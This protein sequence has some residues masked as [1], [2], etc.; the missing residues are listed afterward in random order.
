MHS[1]SVVVASRNST[2]KESSP[3]KPQAKSNRAGTRAHTVYHALKEDICTGV[4]VPNTQLSEARIAVQYGTSRTPVREALAALE[5]EG[6]VE[7]KRG[8]GA[9]VTPVTFTDLLHI[10]ELR[11]VLEP[12]AARTAYLH[13]TPDEL[14]QW[15]RQFQQLLKN[16]SE[17]QAAII[18]RINADCDFHM[19]V[20]HKSE[21]PFIADM[22]ELILPTIRR[23]QVIS[24]QPETYCLEDAVDQHMQLLNAL[25]LHDINLFCTMLEKHLDWSLANYLRSHPIIS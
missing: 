15:R 10:F 14:G 24:Y 11:K 4:I 25:E 18:K 2:M 12:M 16:T 19:F 3:S 5:S 17:S 22:M 23:L 7:I 20:V 13:I 8:I 9:I 6:L 1:T 21:N